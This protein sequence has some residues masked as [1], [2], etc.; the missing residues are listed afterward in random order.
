[1]YRL[2]AFCQCLSAQTGLS[3]TEAHDTLPGAFNDIRH[4]YLHLKQQKQITKTPI[5][6]LYIP[7]PLRKTGQGSDVVVSCSLYG[8]VGQPQGRKTL[9]PPGNHFLHTVQ[10]SNWTPSILLLAISSVQVGQV[11]S[12]SENKMRTLIILFQHTHTHM[13][14]H[15]H[16]HTHA[17]TYTTHLSKHHKHSWGIL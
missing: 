12:C 17:Y 8:V 1:M 4:N 5:H 15:T 16:T 13:H 3:G 2:G 10:S 9:G 14:T 11:L 6:L 7:L